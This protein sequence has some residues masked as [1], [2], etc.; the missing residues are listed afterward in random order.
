MR[1]ETF[2]EKF[3]QL[4]EAPNTV[5]KLRELVI[6]L[7]VRGKLVANRAQDEP[8]HLGLSGTQRADALPANWRSGALGDVITLEYGENLPAGKRS[9]SGEYPVYGSNGIVGTHDSFLVSD[10]AII[11][12]R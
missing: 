3:E 9:G 1:L 10:P 5:E 11:V 2:F 8:V 7:A 4:A 6:Q 12:G